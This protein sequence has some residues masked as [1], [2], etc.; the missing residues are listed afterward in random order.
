MNLI[1]LFR[2]NLSNSLSHI[3]STSQLIHTFLFD[4]GQVADISAYTTSSK[5]LVSVL[6]EGK[7]IAWGN[8]QYIKGK[9]NLFSSTV[10]SF[11]SVP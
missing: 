2:E 1:L 7:L 10:P 11:D 4:H 3:P 5:A 9:Y 6:T 8:R